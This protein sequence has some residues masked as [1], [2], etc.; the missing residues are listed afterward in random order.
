M[1]LRA[2]VLWVLMAQAAL[3]Q[4]K[5]EWSA[6]DRQAEERYAKGEIK[7]A[8]RIAKLA[9]D[10][11]SGAKQAARSLDRLGFFESTA[12]ETKEGEIHLRRALEMRRSAAGPESAE[13]AESAN[14]LA[15]MLRDAGRLPEARELARQAVAIRTRDR[16]RPL[17]L[18]ESLN[19]L[20]SVSSLF[21]EYEEGIARSEEA[22]AIHERHRA[23]G[24]LG[25]E[26]GTL[27]INLAGTYQRV[28]KY[29]NAAAMFERGLDV[30]RVKPGVEHPAYSASLVAYASLEG[31]M[32]HYT[33]AEKLFD[34][35]SKLVP[36]QLGEQHAV[37]AML[38]NNR[39]TFYRAIGNAAQ[40]EADYRKS[41]AIK[42]KIFPP[43]ALTIAASLRNLASVVQERNRLE[44]EKLFR[45]AVDLYEKN[46]KPPPFD[47]ASALRGL[48][49][50][51]R[52]RGDIV[53]ARDTLR[54][55]TAVSTK[56]LGTSHPLHAALLRDLGL[57]YAASR[58]WDEAAGYL[59]KAIAI[60]SEAQGE[61]HPDLALYQQRLAV[62]LEE[63][64]EMEGATKAYRR[65]FEISNRAMAEI[66][67]IGSQR[68]KAAVLANLEDPVPALL[69]FQEKAGS[70]LPG[71]R[72]L[73]FEAVANRKGRVL[74]QVH[75]WGRM[76]RESA[77]EGTRTRFRQWEAM[78]ECQSALSIALGYRDLKPAVGGSCGLAGTDL[79]GIYERLLHELRTSWTQAS[80]KRGMEAVNALRQRIDRSEAEMSREIPQFASATRV[81]RFDEIQQGLKGDEA[82]IEIVVHQR[83]NGRSY[84]AFVLGSE[85]A[86]GWLDLGPAGAV[87]Q[88]VQDLIEAANDWSRATTNNER[89][90]TG[91]SQSS[92]RRA[93]ETISKALGPVSGWLR[94]HPEVRHVRVAPEGMLNLAP[95]AALMDERGRP[96]IERA[97]IS[98]V[99]AG[100]DVAARAV[101]GSGGEVMIAV[102]PGPGEWTQ[103]GTGIA[104]EF[105]ADRL[106]SLPG[107]EAEAQELKKRLPLA[108]MLGRGEA[109]EQRVKQIRRPGLLHIV[110]HGVVKGN[111]NCSGALA[112]GG[113]QL[114]GMD[115][116]SRAMSLSAIVLEETYGRGSG[117]D[118]DGLLTALEMQALDLQGSEMLVLSQCR[119]AD[120]APSTGDG[121]Y[122]MRR[123]AFI[124]GVR[125]FVAPLWNV[126]DSAQKAL[127]GAF[128]KELASGTGK[129]EALRRAQLQLRAK[130]Q[131]SSFLFWG[132]VILS[133]DSGRAPGEWFETKK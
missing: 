16:E 65:S 72:T 28:G 2:V 13:Y 81:V 54:Q 100:R 95:F 24:E 70:R 51:Q 101:R 77:D 53:S 26:Y 63:A 25:E 92:A 116:G 62:M 41:L 80:A 113:C 86:L 91:E 102:S 11:A 50:A 130:S 79:A 73:A 90:A 39:G 126:G 123:A 38:L 40:S 23:P 106:Q 125:T 30:L 124:A 17:D 76:L 68:S 82:L 45:E 3:A 20:A 36:K 118:Q 8:I 88:A 15:L 131:T 47:F 87:D 85:A 57:V 1:T 52:F 105:R 84:G 14:D 60:A 31:D 75:D 129:A 12:G 114:A 33:R 46:T 98:Y 119:M 61:D 34:E 120:G 111:E 108:K 66:L 4:E 103:T 96:W 99:S 32:A 19:T 74:D 37:Y 49:E 112:S 89:H 55:A 110:G 35:A 56:G 42:R 93:L 9:V 27:C 133:G 21:G 107:A 69:R 67:S 58:E 97:A 132:P 18:A 78:L 115:A 109:T 64:G 48:A 44:S 5:P 127:M 104:A 83:P 7:E 10:A 122:G 6:L 117:S 128:Y 71:A 94:E 29:A 121:V 43:G 59:R 22:R